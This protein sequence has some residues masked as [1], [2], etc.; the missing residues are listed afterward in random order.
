V[1]ADDAPGT[2]SRRS[3]RTTPADQ[4]RPPWVQREVRYAGLL[5]HLDRYEDGEVIDTKTT[6]SRWLEHIRLNGPDD[7]HLW[8]VTAYGC[9]LVKEGHPVT[10]IGI[11]YIA[12]DSGEE[13]PWRGPFR[14]EL[15]RDALLWLRN[16]RETP[17]DMLPRDFMPDSAFCHS[18][19]WSGQCW[20]YGLE[21]RGPAKVI[22]EEGP[23]LYCDQHAASHGAADHPF[24]PSAPHWAGEL[25]RA[26]QDAKD[27]KEREAR[28]R[29][30]VEAFRPVTGQGLVDAG[31]HRIK[32][33]V[34]TR[35][36]K[37]VETVRFVSK[38]SSGRTP[39][40]GY[41]EGDG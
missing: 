16:V 22:A 10:G 37:S 19:P 26:K 15:M 6:S 23:C 13:Y 30:A 33:G 14:P 1:A 34:Q 28:A 5:G 40:M 12:R 2:D 4:C 8:Q 27:A 31:E 35:N 3:H 7:N 32:F 11:D 17:L 39:A 38:D 29:L 25:W 36:D 21:G 24:E 9:A 20:P 41:D 18:C